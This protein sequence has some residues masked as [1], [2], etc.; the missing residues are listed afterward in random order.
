MWR[1]NYY[2][3]PLLPQILVEYFVAKESSL[4]LFRS[5]WCCVQVLN[6]PLS[7]Q[8]HSHSGFWLLTEPKL[9]A[10]AHLA[11]NG[12]PWRIIR[13]LLVWKKKSVWFCLG[14]SLPETK[15]ICRHTIKGKFWKTDVAKTPQLPSP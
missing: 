4:F 1:P 6:R 14:N 3:L 11:V 13:I 12:V 15:I 7:R 9:W 8:L 2:T 5:L 10:C